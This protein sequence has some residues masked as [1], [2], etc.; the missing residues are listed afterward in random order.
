MTLAILARVLMFLGYLGIVSADNLTVGENI[1]TVVG[2]FLT[3]GENILTV[4]AFFL[5]VRENII[6]I[7]KVFQRLAKIYQQL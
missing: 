4:V 7:M 1:L 2:V 3:V 6:T 5:T